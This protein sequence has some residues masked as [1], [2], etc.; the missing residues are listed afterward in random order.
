MIG[1]ESLV[2]DHKSLPA[3]PHPSKPCRHTARDNRDCRRSGLRRLRS[4]L[5]DR[6][7][8]RQRQLHRHCL[9]VRELLELR[10]GDILS[11]DHCRRLGRS[12]EVCR[13]N[14]G[15]RVG[16]GPRRRSRSYGFHS[17]GTIT[18]VSID[19]ILIV[20]LFSGIENAVAAAAERT[21]RTTGGV[22]RCGIQ[23]AAVTLFS[24]VDLAVSA[25]SRS[26]AA[27]SAIIRKSRIERGLLA[28]FTEKFLN[29]AVAADA[30]L[31][32][33]DV[34]TAV[35]IPMVAVITLFDLRGCSFV[36]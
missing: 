28:L 19:Q 23:R 21:I 32:E 16:Q 27:P 36:R 35:I 34:S 18:P 11:I 17:T 3:P 24:E 13:H 9:E 5:H 7:E 30:D 20:A 12:F 8:L 14:I 25:A 6:L 2:T 26:E 15:S 31:Q 10:E 22:C 33:A 29:D 1:Y 4:V